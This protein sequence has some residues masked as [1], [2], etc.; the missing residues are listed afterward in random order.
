MLARTLEATW[1][2]APAEA[3]RKMI[4][5]STSG[6]R[7]LAVVT[8]A[9]LSEARLEVRRRAQ[10]RLK[11]KRKRAVGEALLGPAAGEPGDGAESA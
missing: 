11:L 6:Q 9:T 3:I 5:S 7:V 10:L 1:Q 2:A 8:G 4:G